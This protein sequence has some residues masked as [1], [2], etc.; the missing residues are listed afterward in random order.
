MTKK[1]L[2]VG[3]ILTSSG[4]GNHAMQVAEYLFNLLDHGADFQLDIQ[5][6]GCGISPYYTNRNDPFLDRI[7]SH[8]QRRNFEYDISIQ[9]QMPSPK[10]WSATLA[11]KNIGVTAGIETNLCHSHWIDTINTMDDVIVPS[12]F[13]K[14]AF[15]NSSRAF[16]KKLSTPVTVVKEFVN[17]E[18][19]K[20]EPVSV[21][22]L[23][24]V[25]T[26][27][28]L[29]T[30]GQLT[31]L[32]KDKDRKNLFTT[33]QTF[34]AAF[35]NNPEV[36]L[37]VKTNVGRET[38]LDRKYCNQILEQIKEA[39]CDFMTGQDKQPKLYLLH[40]W[41][42]REEIRS[43]YQSPKIKALFTTTRGEAVG[44]PM[45]E[46]TACGLPVIATDKGG[47]TEYLE[48]DKWIGLPSTLQTI[49]DSKAD[50]DVF[51]R[52]SQWFEVDPRETVEVLKRFYKNNSKP[53]EW[54]KEQSVSLQKTLSKDKIFADYDLV[55]RKYL[56]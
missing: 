9:I 37:V 52:G 2:L 56:V 22:V 20:K 50:N 41:M 17:E 5:P 34:F 42:N 23:S 8:C 29:F 47:H 4:Y 46:A 24:G 21:N 13:S 43:V 32:D 30:F 55:F 40:G 38:P 16:N 14:I 44:L 27:F 11:T 36:G 15:E 19:Y 3:P 33:I 45:V 49:H 26:P 39:T 35:H 51:V 18:F 1:V 25:K 28:N 7:L 53:R 48:N 54:A 10:E 12:N 6:I 31:G